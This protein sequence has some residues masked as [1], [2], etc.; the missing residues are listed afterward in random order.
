MLISKYDIIVLSLFL[1]LGVSKLD[2][3]A[4]VVCKWEFRP[5]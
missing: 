1:V 5:K 4:S 3:G 2:I